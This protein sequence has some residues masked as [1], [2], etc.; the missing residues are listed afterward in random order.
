MNKAA[1]DRFTARRNRLTSHFL[2]GTVFG[3]GLG[4]VVAAMAFSTVDASRVTTIG[5]IVAFTGWC[6]RFLFDGDFWRGQFG[7]SD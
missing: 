2:A 1:W 4:L 5:F 7:P 3:L 6:C